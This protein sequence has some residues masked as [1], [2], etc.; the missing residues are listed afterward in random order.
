MTTMTVNTSRQLTTTATV[1]LAS[2]A[3][4]K[5]AQLSVQSEDI[6]ICLQIHNIKNGV[7]ILTS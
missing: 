4:I 5:Q 1:T 7:K 2:S 6:N 3:G